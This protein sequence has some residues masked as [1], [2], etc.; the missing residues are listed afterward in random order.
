[1]SGHTQPIEE[2]LGGRCMRG[3]LIDGNVSLSVRD[4]IVYARE[5][6]FVNFGFGAG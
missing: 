6:L 2:L 5:L 4:D 1:M 3:T